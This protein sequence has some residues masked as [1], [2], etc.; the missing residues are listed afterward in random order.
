MSVK[1]ERFT[2]ALAE[3]ERHLKILA[4]NPGMTATRMTGY[5]GVHPEKVA[6]VI[7]AVASGK[8]RKPSG[9]DVDVWE[10]I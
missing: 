1:K 5:R 7:F 10:Y 9:S 6:K 3:E 4:V 2:Q 8:I